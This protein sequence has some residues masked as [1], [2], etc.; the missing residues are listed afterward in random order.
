[1]THFGNVGSGVPPGN[2]FIQIILGA[3][4]VPSL[5]RLTQER[6]LVANL[7]RVVW[8]HPLVANYERLDQERHLVANL[9]W[10]IWE[11]SLVANLDRLG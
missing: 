11:Y 5:E 2:Q 6:H 3:P 7:D 4:I 1:M 8:E 9:N 10:F